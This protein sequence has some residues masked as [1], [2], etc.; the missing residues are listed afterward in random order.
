[1][2]FIRNLKPL[3]RKSI[4]MYEAFALLCMD[5]EFWNK[6][7]MYFFHPAFKKNLVIESANAIV[8]TFFSNFSHNSGSFHTLIFVPLFSFF[9][10]RRTLIICHNLSFTLTPVQGYWRGNFCAKNNLSSLPQT[11]W[12]RQFCGHPYPQHQ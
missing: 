3:Y 12:N 7:Y 11:V 9:S 4:F 6:A 1:M 10:L 2:Y 8:S 5:Q